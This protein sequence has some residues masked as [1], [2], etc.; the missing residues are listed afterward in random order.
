[1]NLHCSSKESIYNI[2]SSLKKI[3]SYKKVTISFDEDHSI[4]DHPWWWKQLYDAIQEAH[5]QVIFIATT[6]RQK[7]Y[8]D[9]C[10]LLSELQHPNVFLQ[11]WHEFS[12]FFLFSKS[13]QHGFH[14]KPKMYGFLLLVEVSLLCFLVWILWKFISPNT[15]ITITPHYG[16][17]TIAT[18]IA[19][20]TSNYQ[21]EKKQVI[22]LQTW[23]I[24]FRYTLSLTT[25]NIKYTT[26]PA[27]WEIIIYSYLPY[28]LTLLKGTKIIADDGSVFRTQK[29]TFLY[30]SDTEHPTNTRVR[31]VALE[32]REDGSIIGKEG[33]KKK[34]TVFLIKNLPE[35][36][37]E[38]KVYA[39]ATKDFL[40]WTTQT[41]GS[42]LEKDI[43]D[44]KDK[45]LKQVF[46][47]KTQLLQKRMKEQSIT[48]QFVLLFPDLIQLHSTAF[49]T[50]VLVGQTNPFVEGSMDGFLEYAYLPKQDVE[51]VFTDYIQERNSAYSILKNIN[52]DSLAFENKRSLSGGILMVATKVSVT[53]QYD[54]VRDPY[55]LMSEIREKIV[56]LSKD[57]ALKLLLSYDFIA[58]STIAITPWWY[59]SVSGN[60]ERIKFYIDD[61]R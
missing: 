22:A 7:E 43:K 30:A 59:R 1:M 40:W 44:L 47:E 41:I 3:A 4:F 51:R 13:F 25:N 21:G 32:Y 28:E 53:Q 16:L 56:G 49:K 5:L 20:V 48:D 57:E 18:N 24:D 9:A 23:S 15:I 11:R 17:D 26:Q 38:K 45:I 10:N 58:K 36:H 29:E 31:V 39:E 33:N 50:N 2:L 61:T 60:P 19:V 52:Y 8:F 27:Q 14:S 54:F 55:A 42:V 12:G 46:Q 6:Q 35:T 37:K 34:G